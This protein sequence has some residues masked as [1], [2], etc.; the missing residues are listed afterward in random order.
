MDLKTTFLN[1]EFN[2]EIYM[3]QPVGFV[4]KAQEKK[5]DKL[6]RSIYGLNQSS[7]QWYMIFHKDVMSFD[8]TMID[9]DHCIY[10]KMSNG[11]L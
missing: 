3:K 4:V 9:E 10:V 1:G 7:K 6:K 5:V 2:E 8:F 11:N